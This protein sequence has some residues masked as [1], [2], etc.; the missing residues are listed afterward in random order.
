MCL[1]YTRQTHNTLYFKCWSHS[2]AHS[3]AIVPSSQLCC[4]LGP[5]AA[6][7]TRDEPTTVLRAFSVAPIDDVQDGFNGKRVQSVLDT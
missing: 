5:A 3:L 2:V 6:L 1:C 7:H 4:L